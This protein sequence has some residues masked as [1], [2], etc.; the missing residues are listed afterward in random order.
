M[1]GKRA[2]QLRLRARRMSSYW[3][4]RM[5][6]SAPVAVAYMPFRQNAIVDVP[7]H[8]TG[9]G[10]KDA[11]PLA[12]VPRVARGTPCVLDPLCDRAVYQYMKRGRSMRSLGRVRR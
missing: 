11:L 6:G 10:R 2:K 1:N 5:S 8:S 9:F 7:V 12:T 3:S 4:K